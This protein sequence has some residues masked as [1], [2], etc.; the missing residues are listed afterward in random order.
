MLTARG[1]VLLPMTT[2]VV[3]GAR[4]I[5]VPY[6]ETAEPGLRVWLQNVYRETPLAEMVAPAMVIAVSGA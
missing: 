6:T 3:E 2:E 4:L 5:I 1:A